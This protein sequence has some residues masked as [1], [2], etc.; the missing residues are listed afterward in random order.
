MGEDRG[1]SQGSLLIC[2]QI[3]VENSLEVNSASFSFLMGEERR[4]EKREDDEKRR[5]DHCAG[6]LQ[7]PLRLD[8]SIPVFRDLL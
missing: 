8:V 4:E 1:R 5:E 6:S 3:T 7:W 2:L